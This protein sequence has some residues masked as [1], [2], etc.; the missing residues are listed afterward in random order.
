MSLCHSRCIGL[1]F[2]SAERVKYPIGEKD[3]LDS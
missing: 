3:T 2:Y 1:E